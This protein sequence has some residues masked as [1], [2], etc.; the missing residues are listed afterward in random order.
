[1]VQSGATRRR[2]RRTSLWHRKW[3]AACSSIALRVGR[4]RVDGLVLVC[5]NRPC[6]QHDERKR[7]RWTD[8]LEGYRPRV[9]YRYAVSGAWSNER[10]RMECRAR[11]RFFETSSRQALRASEPLTFNF[12]EMIEGVM[13]FCFGTS[14]SW[15]DGARKRGV[16]DARM[17]ARHTRRQQAVRRYGRGR[18]TIFS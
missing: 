11:I 10:V 12:S 7:Q 4:P 5:Q 17:T 14:V 8:T 6:A 9:A 3:P 15:Q 18:R 16:R 1:M 13:S 2:C